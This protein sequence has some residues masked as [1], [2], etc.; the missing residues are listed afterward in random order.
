[1]VQVFCQVY[2]V[3][4]KKGESKQQQQRR[5]RMWNCGWIGVDTR[6]GGPV[7][8][9]GVYVLFGCVGVFLAWR[10]GTARPH[11]PLHSLPSTS[12]SH[13]RHGHDASATGGGHA[14]AA[15]GSRPVRQ[16][17]PSRTLRGFVRR[18][19]P[20]VWIVFVAAP[21]RL[22]SSSPVVAFR[23]CSARTPCIFPLGGDTARRSQI[24]KRRRATASPTLW[25]TGDGVCAGV[26]SGRCPVSVTTPCIRASLCR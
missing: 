23:R 15:R 1:M 11:P 20:L 26:G 22:V 5:R 4:G 10:F 18:A 25:R 13:T 17:N 14:Q 21:L 2:G 19:W 9:A 8:G 7:N 24:A 6:A 3:A 12:R 16:S